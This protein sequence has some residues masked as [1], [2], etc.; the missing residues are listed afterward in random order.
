MIVL[1]HYAAM[2]RN[3]GKHIKSKNKTLS[4]FS[5]QEE[6]GHK[7]QLSKPKSELCT[8]IGRN[9]TIPDITYKNKKEN[10]QMPI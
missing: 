1:L 6:S 3:T 7:T 10:P 9:L 4:Q 2:Q 5:K 8:Y